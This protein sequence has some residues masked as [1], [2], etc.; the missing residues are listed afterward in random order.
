MYFDSLE[1][2]GEAGL[3]AIFIVI[4]SFFALNLFSLMFRILYIIH[5]WD[6]W[7]LLIINIIPFLLLIISIIFDIG[8]RVQ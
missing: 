2:E 7:V 5:R 4:G 6:Y 8:I 3:A 1:Y